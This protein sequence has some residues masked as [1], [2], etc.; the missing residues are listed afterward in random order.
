MNAGPS[1]TIPL[2]TLLSMSG[3]EAMGAIRDGRLPGPRSPG[4]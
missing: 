3:L 2:E 4:S 1:E